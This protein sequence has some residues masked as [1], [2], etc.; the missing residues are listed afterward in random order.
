MKCAL[1]L[2]PLLA[3]IAGC[4]RNSNLN[5]PAELKPFQSAVELKSYLVDQ[6]NNANRAAFGGL[7]AGLF[8]PM[9]A[10]ARPTGRVTMPREVTRVRISRRKGSTRPT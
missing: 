7:L 10:E 2:L 3:G 8:G 5:G 1:W 9:A 4:P 6:Y